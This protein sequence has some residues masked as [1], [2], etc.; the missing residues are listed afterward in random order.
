MSELEKL[1]T[2]VREAAARILEEAGV[3]GALAG[4]KYRGEVTSR[5]KWLLTAMAKADGSAPPRR[6]L[7]AEPGLEEA[8]DIAARIEETR[9]AKIKAVGGPDTPKE[10]TR[11][12]KVRAIRGA[13]EK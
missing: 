4:N 7:D 10:E 2:P 13:V 6:D 12:T 9:L 5:V 11:L 8:A 3:G 1:F